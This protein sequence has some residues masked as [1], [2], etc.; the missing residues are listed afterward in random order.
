MKRSEFTRKK[1][2]RNNKGVLIYAIIKNK[3]INFLTKSE[4]AKYLGINLRTVSR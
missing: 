1:H 4:A 3:N 2:K